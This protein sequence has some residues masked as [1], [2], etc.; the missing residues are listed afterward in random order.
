VVIHE[1]DHATLARKAVHVPLLAGFE[2]YKLVAF[3][4]TDGLMP[5]RERLLVPD[6]RAIS[7]VYYEAAKRALAQPARQ[8]RDFRRLR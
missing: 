3:D 6:L 4:N 2:V 1:L 7:R 5:N 8:P